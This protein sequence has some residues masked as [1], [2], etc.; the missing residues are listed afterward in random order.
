[1][2]QITGYFK[3]HPVYNSMI[4]LLIGLG[5]G[6]LLTYPV[7]GSHPL[8]WGLV[9]VTIGLLGHLYPLVLKNNK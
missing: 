4:H 7:F 8:R 9:L 3:T 1:M 5:I 6:A 2:K